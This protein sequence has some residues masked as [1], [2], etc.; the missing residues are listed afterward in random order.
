[1]KNTLPQL[2]HSLFITDA[3]LETVMIFEKGINLPEF[4]A[5]VMLGDTWQRALL[6]QYYEQYVTIAR[7][8]DAGLILEA[9]TWRASKDWG[10]KLGYTEAA[11]A[12]L[13]ES[14]IALLWSIRREHET[15]Q[16]PMVISGCIGP[17]GD[18]YNPASQMDIDTA[19]QYHAP[20][21]ASFKAAGADMVGAMTMTYPEEAIGIV[22]A[23]KTL[24]MPVMIAFTVEI[25]GKLPCG[26]S[27]KNAIEQVDRATDS[28]AMYYMINCAHP[29]HF[30][31][32]L[33]GDEAW[34]DRIYGIRA[35]ASRKS[36]AE[37]DESET[38]DDG[39]PQELGS[40]YAA[41]KQQLRNLTI[42]GGCCGTDHRHVEAVCQA[43]VN[44]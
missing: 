20:Q 14:A 21:I 22:R 34:S 24:G 19:A 7:Q 8:Y 41:L 3:G 27:L 15:A 13:N 44:A 23:A 39:N 32:V 12:E 29:S 40:E 18:G 33:T 9:P 43:Y 6:R 26:I 4:A 25:D 38:L 35:N 37:L 16:S 10:E 28:A 36:H 30:Q 42:L 17:R 31:S 2:N 5:F 11:L 1:M